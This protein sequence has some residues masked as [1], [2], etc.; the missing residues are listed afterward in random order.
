MGSP[1]YNAQCLLEAYNISSQAEV[2]LGL[3][4]RS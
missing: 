4:V 1:T 2:D 3:A